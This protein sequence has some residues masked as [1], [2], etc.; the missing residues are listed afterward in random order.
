MATSLNKPTWLDSNELFKVA[1][2]ILF[3]LDKQPA[4]ERSRDIII[5]LSSKD[6][7][8][9][10]E[11]PAHGDAEWFWHQIE[12]AIADGVF[13]FEYGRRTMLESF[14]TRG[15]L[16]FQYESEDQLRKWLDH[17]PPSSGEAWKAALLDVDAIELNVEFLRENPLGID[18]MKAND[19]L[20]ALVS[21]RESLKMSGPQ[22]LRHIAATHF[23]GASKALDGRGEV[24]LAKAIR[25]EPK[26]ITPRKIHLTVFSQNPDTRSVLFIENLD[27]FEACCSNDQFSCDYILVYLSGYKGTSGRIRNPELVRVFVSGNCSQTVAEEC[28][29]GASAKEVFVWTDLD[30]SGLDIAISLRKSYPELQLLYQAYTSMIKLLEEGIGHS[31]KHASKGEQRPPNRRELWGIGTRC[32]EIISNTQSFIDQEAINLE[33]L[34]ILRRRSRKGKA[35]GSLVP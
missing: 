7:S 17:P 35:A 16:R 11:P 22:T 34:N 31:I 8:V 28:I 25:V 30:Y 23:N 24:W 6:F 15:K 2:G 18:G 4:T 3:K 26:L 14:P 5:N 12:Q 13:S 9:L 1:Q 33:Y 19:I 20:V 32:M 10:R 21:I 29:I 27:T